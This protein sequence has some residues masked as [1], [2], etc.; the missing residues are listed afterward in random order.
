MQ[1]YLFYNLWNYILCQFS[2]PVLPKKKKVV[3]ER[4]TCDQWGSY[5]LL[6]KKSSSKKKTVNIIEKLEDLKK[7]F[8]ERENPNSQWAKVLKWNTNYN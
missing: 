4:D 8:T 1:G 3:G 6:E 5:H 7:H 2:A